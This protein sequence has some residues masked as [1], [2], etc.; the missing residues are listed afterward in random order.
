MATTAMAAMPPPPIKAIFL[1]RR[2]RGDNVLAV[3][4][5]GHPARTRWGLVPWIPR[6]RNRLRC[7]PLLDPFHLIGIEGWLSK[8]HESEVPPLGLNAVR[9]AHRDVDEHTRLERDGLVPV[10][11]RPATADNVDHVR[12]IVMPVWLDFFRDRNRSDGKRGGLEPHLFGKASALL[13]LLYL[14]A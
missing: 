14:V 5:L 3:V 11:H 10:H 7:Q 9:Q 13:P 4:R 2:R 1:T 12:S 8:V 6:C